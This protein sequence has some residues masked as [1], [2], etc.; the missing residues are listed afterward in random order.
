MPGKSTSFDEVTRL[1]PFS[2]WAYIE[3][4]VTTPNQDIR[5]KHGLEPNDPYEV[6]YWPIRKS[7][8]CI[9]SDSTN[10]ANLLTQPWTSDYIVI[11]SD[12]APVTIELFV[13]IPNR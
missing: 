10:D 7:R 1:L 11:R 8:A 5:V 2:S 9:I 3:I 13:F 4:S 6:R 12:T